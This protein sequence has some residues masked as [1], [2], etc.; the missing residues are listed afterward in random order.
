MPGKKDTT[1]LKVDIRAET[2]MA[3]LVYNGKVTAWVPKSQILDSSDDIVVG[4]PNSIE[5]AN[6]LAADKDL[7]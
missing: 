2:D 3:V 5:V 4:K 1:W 7:V 6:W